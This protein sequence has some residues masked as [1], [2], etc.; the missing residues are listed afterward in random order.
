VQTIQ[1]AVIPQH[2]G[3]YVG[4]VVAESGYQVNR[5]NLIIWQKKTTEKGFQQFL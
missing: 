2:Q 3:S 1:L 5:T 4:V